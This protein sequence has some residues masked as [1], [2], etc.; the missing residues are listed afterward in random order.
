[1]TTL[2]RTSELVIQVSPFQGEKEDEQW[3]GKVLVSNT[4]GFVI[5][6]MRIREDLVSFGR[7]VRSDDELDTIIV[8]ALWHEE[9]RLKFSENTSIPYGDTILVRPEDFE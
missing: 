5:A 3:I 8:N 6:N 7:T 2:L 1:M 4:T 9:Q